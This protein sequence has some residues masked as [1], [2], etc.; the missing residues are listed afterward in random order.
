MSDEDNKDEVAS[1]NPSKKKSKLLK[2]LLILGVLFLLLV[3]GIFMYVNSAAFVRGQVF[4]RVQ[5]KLKQPVTADD[6]DFSVFSG[7]E[8]KNFVL[9]DE[10]FLKAGKLKVGYD[11]WA[12]ISKNIILKE[13]TLEDVELYVVINRDGKL[14]LLENMV[15]DVTPDTPPAT[16]PTPPAPASGGQAPDIT[17]DINNI[18][19]KNLKLY[20]LKDDSDPEKKIELDVKDFSFSLPKMTAGEDFTFELALALACKA[21][22]QFN[23]KNGL[24]K[25]SGKSRLSK[26]LQPELVSLDLKIDDL[27]ATNNGTN[28]PL[29]GVHFLADLGLDGQKITINSCRISDPR[30]NSSSEIE[31]KGMADVENKQI[32][33]DFAVKQVDSAMLDLATPVLSGIDFWQKW[34]LALKEAS[35]GRISGFGETVINYQGEVQQQPG[36]PVKLTGKLTLDKLPL[37]KGDKQKI[38]KNFSTAVDYDLSFDEKAQL[39]EVN[40]FDIKVNEQ[41]RNLVNIGIARPLTFDVK[42]KKLG[43]DADE[44][45]LNVKKFNS[46]YLKPFMKPEERDLLRSGHV[47][48]ELKVVSKA[49]GESLQIDMQN[50]SVDDLHIVKDEFDLDNLRFSTQ[51]RM[52]VDQLSQVKVESIQ[53]GL[54]QN[55]KAHFTCQVSGD[56]TTGVKKDEPLKAQLAINNFAV[57]PEVSQFIP[58]ELKKQFKLGNV[59]LGGRAINITYLDGGIDLQGA[60]FTKDIELG[61]EMLNPVKISQTTD[62][63]LSLDKNK[64]LNLKKLNFNVQPAGMDDI[65]LTVTSKLNLEPQKGAVQEINVDLNV[66]K[67]VDVSA[68]MTLLKEKAAVPEGTAKEPSAETKPTKTETPVPAPDKKEKPAMKLSVNSKIRG[69]KFEGELVEDIEVIAQMFNE[70]ITLEKAALKVG[71]AVLAASGKVNAGKKKMVDLTVSTEGAI[72]LSPVNNIINKGTKQKLSGKVS[73]KNVRVKTSGELQQQM[74]DNLEAETH[75]EVSDIFLENYPGLPPTA[76]KGIVANI[77]AKGDQVDIKRLAVNFTEN[78]ALVTSG[79]A[80]V[81]GKSKKANIKMG[82]EGAID[83]A[84]LNPFINTGTKKELHGKVE[85]ENLELS[86]AGSTNEELLTNLTNK[87]SI[88]TNDIVLKNY[89]PDL[90]SVAALPLEYIFG[91]KPQELQFTEGVVDINYENQGLN[92]NNIMLSS[93]Q[94]MFN[95]KGI[96]KKMD[97]GLVIDLDIGLG[98]GGSEFVK[99]ALQSPQL[100]TML[101][102]NGRLGLTNFKKN[103]TFSKK[104]GL[105]HLNNNYAIKKKFPGKDWNEVSAQIIQESLYYSADLIGIKR[106]EMD[107]LV[108]LS[109]GDYTKALQQQ[110]LPLLLKKLSKEGVVDPKVQGLLNSLAGG[111]GNSNLL[112]GILGGLGNDKDSKNDDGK[113]NGADLIQ[114]ILGGMTK[115]KDQKTKVKEGEE[116]KKDGGNDLIQGLIGIGLNELNKDKK[117]EQKDQ[118]QKTPPQNQ[119]PEKKPDEKKKEKKEDP[120]KN[121]FENLLK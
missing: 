20:V 18:N 45:I 87:V 86:A 50:L 84:M 83:L 22:S 116:K 12:A 23:L 16:T 31:I 29:E 81:L 32:D 7:I 40:N 28:L 93:P 4:A 17:L 25:L 109:K 19:V 107:L 120:L 97:D 43:S 62:F 103:F 110:G 1:V 77:G 98:F 65:D 39:L 92:L 55:E 67:I 61:G 69:V 47:S 5:D 117:K 37:V 51:L 64:I 111:E 91:V 85:F 33:V 66:S 46:D 96:I 41:L 94:F 100:L 73:L 72:D 38:V 6:I 56:L 14:K 106:S 101:E 82:T 108:S 78:S 13:F 90:P 53:M 89:A 54:M 68:L 70:E 24:V 95:P 63:D 102:N 58:A 76:L 75:I 8:L 42:N 112:Q 27:D 113:N 79:S 119:Q 44:I 15:Q 3:G 60:I 52:N 49:G 26:Q 99:A 115:D 121:I 57:T 10:P 36:K 2:I 104:S 80:S 114:G 34:Q 11:L 74:I 21:G 71:N 59:N 118:Q 30:E 105:Y 35:E 88:K 48:L 9:G